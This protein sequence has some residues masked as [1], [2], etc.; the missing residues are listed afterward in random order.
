MELKAE[1]KE[2][3]SFE[4]EQLVGERLTKAKI[5]IVDDLEI[6]D[7]LPIDEV[8]KVIMEKISKEFLR[9]HKYTTLVFYHLCYLH[10]LDFMTKLDKNLFMESEDYLTTVTFLGG[11][12][13]GMDV[14]HIESTNH[15]DVEYFYKTIPTL[16]SKDEFTG[17]IQIV[18]ELLAQFPDKLSQAHKWLKE[19]AGPK[20]KQLDAITEFANMIKNGIPKQDDPRIKKMAQEVLN[21][22]IMKPGAHSIL[23]NQ[24]RKKVGLLSPPDQVL[25][26]M[27]KILIYLDI[28]FYADYITDSSR[29]IEKL[30]FVHF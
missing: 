28:L 19:D 13:K 26:D 20:K 8:V 24:Q 2:W 16:F 9:R 21:S 10:I 4:I 30:K 12:C 29:G 27:E 22:G 6:G 5:D 3:T 25:C 11:Y 17:I 7:N 1:P 23:W 15:P 18:T 14:V